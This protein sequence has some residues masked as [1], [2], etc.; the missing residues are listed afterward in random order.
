MA[1]QDIKKEKLIS[2]GYSGSL[3]NMER[4]FYQAEG[5]VGS[6]SD[7]DLENSFL[8]GKGFSS[9]SLNDKWRNYLI[10]LGY[11]GTLNNMYTQ[12]WTNYLS[13]PPELG[14]VFD[15]YVATGYYT[16]E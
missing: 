4:A 10:S 11:S 1:L 2:L 14:Y 3:R 8:V 6:G 9:G 5:A 12:F 7:D 15:G 16:P 13:G